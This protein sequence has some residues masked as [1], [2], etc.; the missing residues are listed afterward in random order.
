MKQFTI[1][2]RPLS[3]DTRYALLHADTLEGAVHQ[4]RSQYPGCLIISTELHE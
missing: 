1:R 4:I 2:F 3:S